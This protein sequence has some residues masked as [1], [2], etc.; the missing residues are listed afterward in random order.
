MTRFISNRIK[1]IPGILFLVFILGVFYAR[2]QDPTKQSIAAVL[3]ETIVNDGMDAALQQYQQIRT[4]DSIS[5]HLVET[6]LNGLGYRLINDSRVEDAIEIFKLNCK[7]YPHAFNTWDSLGEAFMIAGDREK[8]I[9]NYNKSIA[10]N[11]E[12]VNGKNILYLLEHYDKK[13]YAVPMRDGVHLTTIV[14]TPRDKS[15][16]YPMLM[17]RTPYGI[18]PYGDKRLPTRLGPSTQMLEEGYI[19]V[20]QDVRGRY[21]SEGE[22]EHMRPIHHDPKQIDE[23]TDTYDTI[24]WLIKNVPGHNGRV[25]MWGISYP[26]F[27]SLTGAISNHPALVAVS[28]QAPPIDWFRGDDF[29]RNGAFY[30][31]QAVNFFRFVGVARPEPTEQRATRILTYTS[32]DLYSFFR[33]V[34]PLKNWNDRY[35][36][37]NIAYW[38]TLMRH[39]QYDTYWEKHNLLPHLDKIDAAVLMVGGWYD[40][41]DLYGPRPR[42]RPLKKTIPPSSIHW[43]W[44]PGITAAGPA[45]MVP[46]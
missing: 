28:P 2:G 29:H 27:Y 40:A 6:E 7:V 30:L 1:T 24:D 20:Y 10:L 12:N 3:Y 35:F 34:G 17:K 9:V 16:T 18:H 46:G 33:Q 5:Y 36:H 31:L 32:P 21:M 26:G 4:T 45:P 11:P 38:D 8:A 25:G 23:S 13:Q 44:A 41:E 43:S 37:H 15:V 14:Y 42:I 22:F 19:F 39:N